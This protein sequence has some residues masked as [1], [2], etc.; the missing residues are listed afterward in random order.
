MQQLQLQT[1]QLK[2][3]DEKEQDMRDFMFRQ[4]KARRQHEKELLEKQLDTE[5]TENRKE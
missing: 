5:K 3:A 4:D 1:D 2:Q